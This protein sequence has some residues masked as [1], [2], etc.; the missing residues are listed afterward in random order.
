MLSAERHFAL[1]MSNVLSCW[2]TEGTPVAVAVSSLLT[3]EC[4]VEKRSPSHSATET[5]KVLG[6]EDV[7]LKHLHAGR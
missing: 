4:P 2:E 3:V 7:S 6:R 5:A 1:G